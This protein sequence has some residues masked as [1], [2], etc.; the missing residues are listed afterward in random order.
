M[1][2]PGASRAASTA[3]PGVAVVVLNWRRPQ[4][5]IAC[6]LSVLKLD[7]SHLDII[8]C[9][10]QSEDGSVETILAGLESSLPLMNEQRRAQNMA[11]FALCQVSPEARELLTSPAD[12]RRLWI[13]STGRNGGYAFGNNVGIRLALLDREVEYVWVLN[14][15]TFV[16][17]HALRALVGQVA[18]DTS[19][20]ICG[21]KV[22]YSQDE[23]QVQTLGGGRFL[24]YRARCEQIG[25]GLPANAPVDA[26]SIEAQLSYVNGAA[27]FV[28][29]E[30][31]EQVGY[32]DEGYFLYWEELDWATR[33]LKSGKFRLGF[34]P[35]AI[36]YHQVGAS[37]GSN[38]HGVPTLG[39]TYWM[40]RSK[41]RYLRIHRPMTLIIAFPLLFKAMAAEVLAQRW[42]R[43]F[44][45]LRGALGLPAAS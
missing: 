36:V 23:G 13:A 10:N 29:R 25:E 21:A 34:C 19:I 37:T 43:A 4:E 17:W 30:L 20:G 41:F 42:A 39:S 24:P 22:L 26:R 31:I 8:V 18:K 3:E 7:Y 40:T 6:V 33:A 11:E 16:D 35:N 38:D 15:D 45:M 1:A 2:A 9:D 5:T 32:M 28:R 27:A 12:R 44:T 14:N